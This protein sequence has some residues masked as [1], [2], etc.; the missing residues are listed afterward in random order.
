MNI[1]IG[2]CLFFTAFLSITGLF[3]FRIQPREWSSSSHVYPS[4]DLALSNNQMYEQIRVDNFSVNVHGIDRE[5]LVEK[6]AS[7]SLLH[8][9]FH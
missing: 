7:D 2:K 9:N 8:S 1:N 4:F 6:I 5:G 3:S